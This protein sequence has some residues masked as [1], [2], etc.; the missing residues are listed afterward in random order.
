MY[1]NNAAKKRATIIKLKENDLVDGGKKP[2]LHFGSSHQWVSILCLAVIENEKSKM[3][4][5]VIELAPSPFRS[6]MYTI[7]GVDAIFPWFLFINKFDVISFPWT[8]EAF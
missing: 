2:I 6:A 7:S 5:L 1:K 4:V 8:S 3:Y